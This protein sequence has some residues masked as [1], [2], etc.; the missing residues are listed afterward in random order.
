MLK[1]NVTGIVLA[2]GSSSRMGKEKGFMEYAG[3]SLIRY[4]LEALE[5][6]CGQIIISAN[7]SHYDLLGYPVQRDIFPSSGPMGGIYSCLLRSETDHNLVLPCDTPGITSEFL[8]ML[9]NESDGFQVVISSSK[10]GLPEPLIG[11]YNKNNTTGLL[12]FIKTGNYKLM[13]Y[14][15]TALVKIIP[16]YK[17]PEIFN[18]NLF[19]NINSPE[20]LENSKGVT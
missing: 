3:K 5:G 4:A 2:G 19:I 14:I 6:L 12:P 8:E 16:I 1:H 13:N 7:S 15:E 18:S 11:Y 20:D 10:P 17:R 9:L